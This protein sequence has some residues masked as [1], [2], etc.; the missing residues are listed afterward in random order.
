MAHRLT[1]G[2]FSD[3]AVVHAIRHLGL[4]RDAEV[5]LDTK[6][7]QSSPGQFTSLRDGEIDIAIT[8]PDNVLLYATTDKQPLGEQLDV[9]MLRS[10]DRG[11]GLA[12]FSLPEFESVEA[13]RGSDIAVDVA[14]SGFALLLF[15]MLARGGVEREEATGEMRVVHVPDD[16]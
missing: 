9:R 2:Q 13:L 11:L 8:S 12:L 16:D 1:I 10:I 3:S 7:V 15:R 5:E 4:D 14:R 6:R